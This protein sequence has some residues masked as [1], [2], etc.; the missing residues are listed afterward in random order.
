MKEI[1]FNWVLLLAICLIFGSSDCM[2]ILY[3]KRNQNEFGPW[4]NYKRQ[5]FNFKNHYSL[6]CAHWEQF[7]MRT[8]TQLDSNNH[9][10]LC[11]KKKTQCASRVEY[12]FAYRSSTKMHKNRVAIPWTDYT[13]LLH[14][15]VWTLINRKNAIQME[16]PAH[17]QNAVAKSLSTHTHACT[18]KIYIN[19]DSFSFPF[20]FH[21]NDLTNKKSII[22]SNN[23][24]KR[25]EPVI[26]FRAR[27]CFRNCLL[28]PSQ[29]QWCVAFQWQQRKA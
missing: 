5:R 12:M 27:N 24:T 21:K 9:V 17:A 15:I 25:N 19:H 10:S 14:T 16:W 20:Y 2:Q 4:G 7:S 11:D 23:N 22:N 3:P 28:N 1:S 26:K 29:F 6:K 18:H 8:D 13:K